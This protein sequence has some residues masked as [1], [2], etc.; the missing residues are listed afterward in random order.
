[1]KTYRSANTASNNRKYFEGST[2]Q[3]D[4]L[5]SL[6]LGELLLGGVAGEQAGHLTHHRGVAAQLLPGQRPLLQLAKES[7]A[8]R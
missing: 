1:M 7:S 8:N 3:R 6:E 5:R 2:N 4:S